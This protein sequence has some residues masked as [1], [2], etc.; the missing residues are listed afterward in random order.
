VFFLVLPQ[1]MMP[2]V[3]VCILKKQRRAGGKRE[4]GCGVG[5]GETKRAQRGSSS[6]LPYKIPARPRW[7]CVCVT[8]SAK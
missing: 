5:A 4:E 2:C 6:T 3:W 7:E 8:S 1:L